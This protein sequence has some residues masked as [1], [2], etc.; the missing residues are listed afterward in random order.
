MIT[1]SREKPSPRIN[2]TEQ[3]SKE[4]NG[5]F[6]E[7]AIKEYKYIEECAISLNNALF[8]KK[9]NVTYLEE[10]K[11]KLWI[12]NAHTYYILER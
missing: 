10:I 11:F 5:D 6:T 8:W 3:N 9:R 4:K 2:V 1:F 12:S 7:N